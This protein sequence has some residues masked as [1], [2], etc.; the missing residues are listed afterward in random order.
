[1]RLFTKSNKD[2]KKELKRQEA[3]IKEQGKQ[4][5]LNEELIEKKKKQIS[6][7]LPKN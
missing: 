5:K 4:I 6:K 7:E 3:K 2:L 1:M